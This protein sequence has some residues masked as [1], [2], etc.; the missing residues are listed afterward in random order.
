M[1]TVMQTEFRH[2]S[3]VLCP[4]GECQSHEKVRKQI[5]L[6]WYPPSLLASMTFMLTP[7]LPHHADLLF[8]GERLWR[9]V[10]SWNHPRQ[11]YW[12]N[13]QSIGTLETLRN[14]FVYWKMTVMQHKRNF[15]HINNWVQ[16]VECARNALPKS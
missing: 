14:E 2:A 8:G 16:Y 6:Y 7:R 10:F 3:S 1:P 5:V 9:A 12:S 15:K 11:I 4:S 13:S